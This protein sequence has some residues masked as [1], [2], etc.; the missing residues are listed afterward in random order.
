[1]LRLLEPDPSPG[2]RLRHFSGDRNVH[3]L[4]HLIGDPVD[5]R[6]TTVQKADPGAKD[7]A[8]VAIDGHQ[9]KHSASSA[10]ISLT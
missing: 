8:R 5:L 9:C 10:F 2:E 6:D 1:M 4:L 7:Q 3:Q